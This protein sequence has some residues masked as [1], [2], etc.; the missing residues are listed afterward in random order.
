[1]A[2]VFVERVLSPGGPDPSPTPFNACLAMHRVHLQE[3]LVADDGRRMLC[4]FTAPDAESVRVALRQTGIAF[5]SGWI[6]R[7]P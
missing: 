4:R 2:D 5:D 6:A 1:M 3:C 7:S